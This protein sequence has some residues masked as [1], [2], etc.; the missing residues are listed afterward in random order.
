MI[1]KKKIE[2]SY[3]LNVA[4][5]RKNKRISNHNKL[6]YPHKGTDNLMY[7]SICK[8]FLFGIK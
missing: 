3:L 6:V 2:S 4:H 8:F 1:D 7:L 5:I